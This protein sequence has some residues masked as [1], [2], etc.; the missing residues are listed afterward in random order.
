MNADTKTGLSQLE[1]RMRQYNQA[2]VNRQAAAILAKYKIPFIERRQ[3]AAL[4]M[5]LEALDRGLLETPTLLEPQLLIVKLME[6]PKLA[7]EL[8]TECLPGETFEIDLPE[9]LELDEAAATVLGVIMDQ[10]MSRPD[11][12]SPY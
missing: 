11:L 9:S 12:V 3:L 8:M 5:I 1:D 7:M 10:I 2:P 4:T 6:M